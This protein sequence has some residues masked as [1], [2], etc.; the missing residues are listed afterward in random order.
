MNPLKDVIDALGQTTLKLDSL[1]IEGRVTATTQSRIQTL[2]DKLDERYAHVRPQD[3]EEFFIRL[4]ELQ[5]LVLITEEKVKKAGE[6]IVD[7]LELM[8][9]A[10]FISETIRDLVLSKNKVNHKKK[11]VFFT[12]PTLKLV[13]AS[14]AT[15]GI[16]DRYWQY[17]NWKIVLKHTNT[18][19]SALLNSVF[20]PL[21]IW[22]L[23]K[24]MKD[25]D[26]KNGGTVKFSP[27]LRTLI[28]W[29][30]SFF[31]FGFLAHIALLGAQNQL[32]KKAASR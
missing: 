10:H 6:F 17:K 11:P 26:N 13:I 19:D 7:A 5:A 20:A 30:L 32:R 23:L 18:Q 24:Q 9:H 28:Y 2:I 31:T 15:I 25:I 1:Y 21:M 3:N 16:Y 29:F 4:Y 12:V 22:S 14:I 27:G 8:P